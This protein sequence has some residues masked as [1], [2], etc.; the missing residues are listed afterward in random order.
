MSAHGET[1]RAPISREAFDELVRTMPESS[2]AAAVAVVLAVVAFAFGATI[3]VWTAW[4]L[5]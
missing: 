5:A 2:R 3:I 4:Q 1:T